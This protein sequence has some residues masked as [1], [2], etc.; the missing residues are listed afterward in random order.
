[1]IDTC[2]ACTHLVMF[3]FVRSARRE[4]ESLD[5]GEIVALSRVDQVSSVDPGDGDTGRR[6]R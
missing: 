4:E 3:V 5:F 6:R 2:D 1:M